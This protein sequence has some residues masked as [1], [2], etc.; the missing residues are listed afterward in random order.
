[1]SSTPWYRIDVV[2][3]DA[4][5]VDQ[6]V[7]LAVNFVHAFRSV[8]HACVVVHGYRVWLGAR[9]S[10]WGET[11]AKSLRDLGHDVRF[12]QIAVPAQPACGFEADAF[13]DAGDEHILG[14]W[15][16]PFP[17]PNPHFLQAKRVIAA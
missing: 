12:V 15:G 7:E 5:I 10:E 17:T 9:D 6:Q 2:A 8:S 1:M 3:G 11:A 13:V 4:D 16:S 14:H